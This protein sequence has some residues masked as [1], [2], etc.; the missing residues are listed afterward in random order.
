MPDWL[1]VFVYGSLLQGGVNHG[2]LREATLIGPGHTL[3]A[4]RLV[5]LGPYP[6]MVA[7]G[8]TAV[9]GEVYRVPERLLAELDRLEEHPETY[10]RST[11]RLSDGREAVAYLLRPR[12]AAGRSEVANGDWRDYLRSRG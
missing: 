9:A 2:L 8:T 4:Y 11:V 7:P 3:P 6:G 10:V 12:H 1:D 5:D